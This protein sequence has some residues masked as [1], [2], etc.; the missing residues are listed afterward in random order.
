M[1]YQFELPCSRGILIWKIKCT[2]GIYAGHYIYLGYLSRMSEYDV[3][4]GYFSGI[5]IWDTDTHALDGR[6]T[7]IQNRGQRAHTPCLVTPVLS[8]VARCSFIS[9]CFF[10]TC[11]RWFRGKRD[12][13]RQLCCS[14]GAE[15]VQR[16]CRIFQGVADAPLWFVARRRASV[17][18]C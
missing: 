11:W 9:A 2:L 16:P 10:G 15:N 5:A 8:I 6:Y 13:M 1:G 3:D 4:Q 12:Q 14:R 17:F 7:I 18:A